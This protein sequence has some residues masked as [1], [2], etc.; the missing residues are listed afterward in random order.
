MVPIRRISMDF[1]I[2]KSLKKMGFGHFKNVQ[3]GLSQNRMPEK[4]MK[5]HFC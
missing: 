3:N 4:F 5:F 1:C 2:P